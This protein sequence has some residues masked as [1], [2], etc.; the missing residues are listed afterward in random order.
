MQETGI[1]IHERAKTAVAIS[2]AG[3]NEESESSME[4]TSA[5]PVKTVKGRSSNLVPHF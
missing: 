5:I 4:G 1:S 3:F 2:R